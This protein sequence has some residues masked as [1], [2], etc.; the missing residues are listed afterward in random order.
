MMLEFPILLEK[1]LLQ[2]IKETYLPAK[3]TSFH[4]SLFNDKDTIFFAKGAKSLS[5]AFTEGRSLLPKNYFSDPRLRSGYLLYFLPVNAMKI[6]QVMQELK[7][8]ELVGGKIR[9]LDLG[10]GPGTGMLGMMTF[11]AD[12]VR[13]GILKEAWCE[14]ALIDQSYPILKDA[15][16]L[17]RLYSAQLERELPGFHSE[18]S[19]KHFD[20]RRENLGRFL[21][22][23]KYHKIILENVLNEF[24][25]FEE[26]AQLTGALLV[27]NLEPQMGHMI[28]IE[29]AL[30]KDSRNLQKL[31]DELVTRQKLAHVYA[32]C[33]HEEICPL[34]VA[35]QRDWC[36]F[37]FR[38]KRPPFIAKVDKAIGNQKDWL[39]CSYMMLGKKERAFKKIFAD[40]EN[41]W[42]VISNLMPSKGKKEIVLC[43]PKGRYHATLLQKAQSPANREFDN[44]K[45]GDLAWIPLSTAGQSWVDH[46]YRVD[47]R[48]NLGRDHQVKI[49]HKS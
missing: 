14:F 46:P 11:Y 31:R 24:G 42:R 39:A 20:M 45:R 48:E 22:K 33:L 28:I 8:D 19:V 27:D 43:G 35:N 10:C 44:L 25:Y 36:H 37:Y 17:H 47:G 21:K 4:P 12:Q 32:P 23:L 34:N 9:I 2:Y 13:R 18:C 3:K 41:S 15:M 7:P 38:W 5:S 49:F 6:V 29:P 26:Q 16:N 1:I 30:K 40:D